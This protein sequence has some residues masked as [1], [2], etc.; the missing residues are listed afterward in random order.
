MNDSPAPPLPAEREIARLR[1]ALA[2]KDRQLAAQRLEALHRVRNLLS[3]IRTMSSRSLELSSSLD[4]LA[5]H[6]SGRL[7]A[8]GRAEAAVGASAAPGVDLELLLRDEWVAVLGGSEEEARVTARGAPVLLAIRAA[9]RL[10][11]AFHEL[12]TN[13]LK[14]GALSQP[15]GRLAVAWK[16]E[17]ERLVLSWIE[18]GVPVVG[19]APRR[20]G[21]GQ[22]YL[23]RA[24]PYDLA[25]V[26]RLEFR[27]GG[28]AFF[29]DLG[30]KDN[31]LG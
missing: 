23:E 8:L 4:D 5:M 7:S 18:S 25:A 21:F 27:P 26:T 15:E 14:F 22:D 9:E 1:E 12:T 11:L 24:L 2:D 3:V 29:L 30:R 20:S 13:A 6:Q 17:G 28:L 10:A 19:S 31:V 16:T